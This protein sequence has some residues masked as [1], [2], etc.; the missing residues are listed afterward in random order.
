[1]LTMYVKEEQLPISPSRSMASVLLVVGHWYLT[2]EAELGGHGGTP[3]WVVPNGDHAMHLCSTL[4]TTGADKAPFSALANL[5]RK[6]STDTH[7][8]AFPRQRD[9]L[10]PRL[11]QLRTHRLVSH[12]LSLHVLLCDLGQDELSDELDVFRV[13][14]GQ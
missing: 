3:M 7:C 9:I 10:L 6:A 12:K 14:G 8:A 13:H 2:L 5:T 1:M 11:S 4:I